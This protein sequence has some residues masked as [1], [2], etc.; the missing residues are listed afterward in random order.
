[1]HALLLRMMRTRY[2]A[3]AFLFQC[4]IFGPKLAG[5]EDDSG[6]RSLVAMAKPLMKAAYNVYGEKQLNIPGYEEHL[7]LEHNGFIGR[8]YVNTTTKTVI[9]TYRGVMLTDPSSV[10]AGIAVS[11]QDWKTFVRRTLLPSLFCAVSGA[12][13]GAGV[14]ALTAKVSGAHFRPLGKRTIATAMLAAATAMG[15]PNALL[16][17]SYFLA[18]RALLKEHKRTMIAFVEENHKTYPQDEYTYY[19]AGHSLGGFWAQVMAAHYKVAGMSFNGPH[20]LE[21]TGPHLP[22]FSIR[23]YG[24]WGARTDPNTPF[25]TCIDHHQDYWPIQSHSI[26]AFI[27]H[28]DEGHCSVECCSCLQGGGGHL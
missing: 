24:D 9:C 25:G 26:E 23:M 4:L 2:A 20:L 13:I 14:S 5:C 11:F 8:S 18:G 3:L 15:L 17:A 28:F 16:L 10:H 1:M 12:C 21:Q 7:H 6:V 27:H 22:F 19:A